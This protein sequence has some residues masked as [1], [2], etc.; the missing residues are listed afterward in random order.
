MLKSTPVW[1]QA[2]AQ[3]AA[4]TLFLFGFASGLPF[5]LVGGTLSVWLK[6]SGVS[7][8]AIGL[9]SLAGLAYALKFLW[10]P[11]VDHYRLPGLQRLGRRRSWLIFAQALLG[12]SLLAMSQIG[13]AQ[14][15]MLFV[16]LTVLAGWAGATQDVVIDAYRIEIAPESSQG[17][18]AATYTLG[19][20]IAL[21]VSGALALF[22]A[23]HL[24]WAIIYAG[25]AALVGLLLIITLL[26]PEPAAPEQ[27]APLTTVSPWRALGQSVVGPFRDFFQRYAGRVGLG[28]LLFIGLFK[29]SDQ[30]LG[31]MALPFYL[32]SGFSK[33]EIASVSKLFGV[34]VGIAGAFIG[35]AAV[36]RFGTTRM[37]FLAIIL[38]SASNLLYLLLAFFPGNVP[39]FVAVIGGENLSGGF[40][41]AVAVAWLSSLVSRQY[42]AT[43]YALFSS[44][45]ALPGKLLG[46][47]SGFM[48]AGMGYSSFFVLS[49]I[50]GIPSL[51]LLL[52]LRKRVA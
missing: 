47:L 19:Y 28:L 29:V 31:V 49:T 23:D 33:T 51:L 32:D 25:M 17:A 6:D 1:L 36:V 52:W 26:S 42:T 27:N 38:G 48:V 5:L 12:L 50:L 46:G 43:Q 18:L 13:P 45:V 10:A 8:E 15:L 16:A 41:G 21:L 7:L 4:L 9:I 22:L 44:L 30:L 20:R 3:P 39:L 35:G 11:L 34:W 14:G 2:F 24:P 37:L 40:L